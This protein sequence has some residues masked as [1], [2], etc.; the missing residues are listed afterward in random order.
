MTPAKIRQLN[1]EQLQNLHR[2][3]VLNLDHPQRSEQAEE[4]LQELHQE[5]IRRLSETRDSRFLPMLGCV[6]Y[7]VRWKELETPE[8][9]RLL[10]WILASELPQINDP[11]FMESWGAPNSERYRS[12]YDTLKRYERYGQGE[13]MA[14]GD[15]PLERR[16]QICCCKGLGNET[17]KSQLVN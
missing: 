15:F 6:G 8:R 3:C 17:A 4:M 16:H 12:V 10:E 13:T 1:E 5:F 2:N 11:K 7:N 9:Q 14:V